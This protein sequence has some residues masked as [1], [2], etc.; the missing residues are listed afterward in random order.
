M[1]EQ[2]TMKKKR[3]VIV[4]KNLR[5]LSPKRQ[6]LV[7]RKPTG[8][9][10]VYNL[11]TSQIGNSSPS[12]ADRT[13]DGS[14]IPRSIL[15][16]P[17]VYEDIERKNK[18]ILKSKRIESRANTQNSGR[19]SPNN[20][21]FSGPRTASPPNP[22]RPYSSSSSNANST[23][24]TEEDNIN[25]N[26]EDDE[27]S[28]YEPDLADDPDQ[29]IAILKKQKSKAINVR[30]LNG[31]QEYKIRNLLPINERFNS[32][33]EGKVLAL[34]QERKAYWD[35]IQNGISKKINA[36]KSH[37]L[38]MASTDDY[39]A[40]TEE[41]DLLQ[42]A[43]PKENRFGTHGWQKSLRGGGPRT[44]AVGHIFSGI[45]C[46]VKESF[47]AP[48]VVRKPNNIKRKKATFID[49]TP[50]IRA[51]QKEL[52]SNLMTLRPHAVTFDDANDLVVKCNGLF[53]WAIDSSSEL[54]AARAVKANELAVDNYFQNAS[55]SGNVDEV[56]L[57]SNKIV[58][59]Q[60]ISDEFDVN[61]KEKI[62]FLSSREVV[63]SSV[64]GKVVH[65]TVSFKNSGITCLSYS[66]NKIENSV[67]SGSDMS[68]LQSDREEL[69]REYVISKDKSCFFCLKDKGICMPGETI[70][71][72]FSFYSK[73][74]GG[75]F[76]QSWRLETK[77]RSLVSLITINL[78]SQS[79]SSVDSSTSPVYFNMPFSIK[80]H[81][82]SFSID[83]STTKRAN[84][85][86]FF[87][88]KTI[89][90][91]KNDEALKILRRQRTPLTLENI[92]ERKIKIFENVNENLLKSVSERYC[93][94]IHLYT[95][96]ERLSLLTELCER[97]TN[98]NVKVASRYMHV[99][100]QTSYI[101]EENSNNSS[102]GELELTNVIF[103]NKDE[104][105]LCEIKSLIFPEKVIESFDEITNEMICTSWD[106]NV[107]NMISAL[108]VS[109]ENGGK[110]NE[111]EKII[112]DKSAADEK[113]RLKQERIAERRAAAIATGDDPDD[114]EE[115]D[116]EEE[117]EEEDLENII[118]IEHPLVIQAKELIAECHSKIFLLMICPNN[119][120]VYDD[121]RNRIGE[122]LDSFD[123]W[124]SSAREHAEITS[125][126]TIVTPFE[127]PFTS[128]TGKLQWKNA[129]N[130]P[131]PEPVDPKAKK[132]EAPKKGKDV[133]AVASEDQSNLY[134]KNICDNVK[135]GLLDASVNF[136]TSIDSRMEL[137][138]KNVL[139]SFGLG[140]NLFNLA[141][142]RNEDVSDGE[143]GKIA[144]LNFT[145]DS[146]VR[147]DYCSAF[148]EINISR[149]KALNNII[150]LAEY[151]ASGIV[152][153]YE[154][155]K[156]SVSSISEYTN[157]MK[158]LLTHLS[159]LRRPPLQKK[160]KN[161]PI[162]P[163]YTHFEF[164]VSFSSSLVELKV[165]INNLIKSKLATKIETG[166]DFIIKIP[167]ILIE[168][169][170]ISNVIPEEPVLPEV[171]SD[172]EECA[173]S[174]GLEESNLFRQ[175]RWIS[176]RPHRVNVTISSG[177]CVDCYAD[178][179]A[180]LSEVYDLA[181]KA[182]GAIW[183]EGSPK[184]IFSPC[185][186][187]VQKCSAVSRVVSNDLR[188]AAV[189]VGVLQNMPRADSL[190][191]E[192]TDEKIPSF[193][194]NHFKSI[195]PSLSSDNNLSPN[196]GAVIGGDLRIE[197]MTVIDHL[198]D[199]TTNIFIVGEVAIP[200]LA[201]SGRIIF[202]KYTSLCQEYRDAALALVKKSRLRGVNIILPTDIIEGEEL[203]QLSDKQKCD[204]YD[205]EA[206]DE[207]GEYEGETKTTYLA[208]PE[209]V[210]GEE[211]KI[212]ENIIVKGYVYDVG[213]ETCKLLEKEIPTYS[214]LFVWGT[215]GVCE[216]SSFQSGQRSLINA[217][218]KSGDDEDSVNNMQPL[219]SI[220]TGHSAVEW[221]S[222]ISDPTGEIG[223][224]LSKYGRIS[225]SCRESSFICGLLSMQNSST[226]KSK[227]LLRSSHENEFI[228][229]IPLKNSE[230]EEEEED[231]EDED[232][233]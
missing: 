183:V 112:A 70:Y 10:D 40:K 7:S 201:L 143:K 160:K 184:T 164:D 163:S 15:G 5:D 159:E 109:L 224:E 1:E 39:R 127:S 177:E 206:R 42:A 192:S 218:V 171:F 126:E 82:H 77:P 147:T 32:N 95:T 216:I 51:K 121:I 176:R 137:K 12:K 48:K 47:L 157:T 31:E 118:V 106:F 108:E 233:D 2:L 133:T 124:K 140:S 142:C 197:K 169:I 62:D 209:L 153:V 139:D 205:N 21:N 141:V 131:E 8:N 56:E 64:Q 73:G 4:V 79:S 172:D 53:D 214:I 54:F 74:C 94:S 96:F 158:E 101:E 115:D 37:S 59:Q 50:Q 168:N 28:T 219:H 146:F 122:S 116:E 149:N 150:N 58:K 187:A 80:L 211:D 198:I 144:F 220:V 213:S 11:E 92:Q 99:L 110:I 83:E 84:I 125:E 43:I 217:S 100:K 114:E 123:S 230:E 49:D 55:E 29:Y 207:G 111:L 30:L 166:N 136:F 93:D 221:Y 26:D 88:T 38:M 24:Q 87:T 34:W 81:G 180:A 138:S 175:Q 72:M 174:I 208:L 204:K 75:S 46:E 85:S 210:S 156:S 22:P 89:E 17:S 162:P 14:Y 90:T 76:N 117:D 167:I 202:S 130:P 19:M 231:E 104:N 67:A 185:S 199:L 129:L 35:N 215:V 36:N 68:K 227:L 179:S 16:D 134:Y 190:L 181:T 13:K 151:G 33:K 152:L 27:D 45:E 189:W 25:N 102:N 86:S 23:K 98:F 105:K 103:A 200:F 145:G 232:E 63:F 6:L 128:E 148:D 78:S 91:E 52:S 193:I 69:P 97:S 9:D 155:D 212:Y 20:N 60:P 223:G 203:I 57:K 228:Y 188:E 226:L 182:C 66:W 65:Q 165:D 229:N 44:I 186:F 135:N 61:S 154:S 113:E 225:Y 191:N 3:T 170:S 132:K 195:F 41:Y 107:N 178:T 194:S 18:D 120:I 161:A 196:F 222:R 71:T 173:I 119:E